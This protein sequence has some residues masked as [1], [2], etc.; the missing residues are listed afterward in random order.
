MRLMTAIV[1]VQDPL[2]LQVLQDGPRKETRE[3]P[4]WR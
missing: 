2:D 1:T 4:V 3:N